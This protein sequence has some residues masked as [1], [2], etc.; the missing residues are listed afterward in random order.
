MKALT[1][2]AQVITWFVL[3][4]TSLLIAGSTVM[5]WKTRENLLIDVDARLRTHA[6]GLI[7]LCDWDEHAEAV[8]FELEEDLADRIAESRAGS[9]EEIYVWPTARLV[10]Q[11]GSSIEAK[12]PG[13]NWNAHTD[14]SEGEAI[15]YAD[16]SDGTGSY[17]HCHVLAYK[18]PDP[19]ELDSQGFTVLI[20]VQEDLAPMHAELARLLGF[21]IVFTIASGL[22]ALLLGYLLARRVVGP[23]QE[24][25]AAASQIR[26][27]RPV[28]LPYRGVD[29]E[30]D[31]LSE[32]LHDAFLRLDEALQRQTRFTS[33]AAHELRNPI[34]VIQNAAE[35]ALR[36]ERSSEDY[37]HFFADVLATS[38]RMGRV[39]DAL[40]LLARLDAGKASSGFQQV[41][42]AEVARDSAS[43][44]A[45]GTER[46]RVEAPTSALV[47]GD[48]GL[49]RILV[50]NL[51]SNALRYSPEDCEVVIKVAS[52]E[53]IVLE[54]KDRGPGIPPSAQ[55]RIF[56][57][58]YRIDSSDPNAL[59]AGLGLAIVA[60]V[61]SVHAV[62]SQVDTSH[63]G[64]TIRV[65]FPHFDAAA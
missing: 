57:R 56:D 47:R 40:L 13:S 55:K 22:L 16:R 48:D 35:I 30:V 51:V 42:L 58:F 62:R 53:D 23:L 31:R 59:G 41:D 25:G 28:H 54:I 20:R 9:S 33:D 44:Q 14:L 39:V 6:T 5:Y 15:E 45:T 4:T 8:E 27:G 34:A 26:A 63:Q 32:H 17:R 2:R 61:A 65:R 64:T 1:L 38:S 10:H 12:L 50:D 36:R 19:E 46:V 49:L 21:M 60:E 24:L 3:L 43:A 52:G 18:P 7:A 11:S 37:Q 29:D